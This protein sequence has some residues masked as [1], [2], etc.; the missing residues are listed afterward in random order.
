MILG[1]ILMYSIFNMKRWNANLIIG[2]DAIVYYEYLPAAFIFNDL[3]FEFLKELPNDFNGTIWV[4]PS[5]TTDYGIPKTSMGMAIMYLPFFA[6]GHVMAHMLNYTAYGYSEPYGMMIALGC[7]IYVFI[8][9]FY[10]R[11][12]LLMYF[13]DIVTT[14]TLISIVLATN[15]FYYTALEPGM[16]HAYSFF[17]I[18]LFIWNTLKWH[19]DKKIKTTIFLGLLF[20]LITLIR[21]TNALIAI[22]FILYGV[23]SFDAFKNKFLLFW[24]EKKHILLLILFA[25]LVWVPQMILWKIST[26]NWLFFSYGEERFYFNNPHIL[27]GLFSYRKGWLLYTPIMAFALLGIFFLYKKERK[28]VVPILCF[29]IINIYVMYSWWC[30]WYGG[31]F[32][33]RPMVDTYALLAIPLAAFFSYFDKKTNYLR[34]ISLFVIFLTTSLNLFQTQQTKTNLHWDGTTKE[35]YLKNFAVWG[36]PKNVW[37]EVVLPDYDKARKGLEEY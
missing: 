12:I 20:G 17:L 11:K 7:F 1:F 8:A 4:N 3:S 36:M 14:L 5:E 37:D 24:K 32:G 10:L 6:I 31:G 13:N 16:S 29:T 18:T 33:C 25:L 27:D 28:F 9:L 26:D 30:W 35:S 19:Q 21:P 2:S 15:L 23:D 34:S 22:V